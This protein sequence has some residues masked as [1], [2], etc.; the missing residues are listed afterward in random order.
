[1]RLFPI[2][3]A[4]VVSAALYLFIFEREAITAFAARGAGESPAAQSAETGTQTAAAAMAGGHTNPV[5]VVALES[6]AQPVDNAVLVRGRTEAA[7]QVTVMAETSGRVVS[8]PLRRGAYVN[9]GQVLCRIDAGTRD[10]TLAEAR[11]RLDEAGTRVPEAQSRLTEAE[12]RLS[13]ARINQNAAE[14]LAK[15]GFASDTRVASAQAA[16]KSAEALVEA[17]G[18]G[19]IAAQSGIAAAEAAVAAAEREIDRLTIAAPFEGLLETDTAE[20][21]SLLQP[22][23]PCATVIQL[24]PIKLVGFVPETEVDKITTGAIAGARLATGSE[25]VGRVTFLS[26]SADPETRTFRVEV[27]VAN[28]DLDIRD[29]Q[30]VEVVIASEGVTAHLVPASALT[31]DD[32]GRLGL[33]LVDADS[34]A[35]FSPVE[36]L[37][38]TSEGVWVSGLPDIATIIVVGQEYVTD[39]VPV[40]ATLREPAQ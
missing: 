22:G 1:M 18:S 38:D 17:A 12:A 21:G 29:G 4:L 9:A 33:R 16:L 36:V 37:R 3:T 27:Q 25:A 40:A 35:V 19:V 10:A 11:A 23:A 7:R 13:E 39:G 34:R 26:R 28:P 31:L 8:E 32:G 5:K 24:N 30:T 15:G 2:V 6:A 14:K 20:L